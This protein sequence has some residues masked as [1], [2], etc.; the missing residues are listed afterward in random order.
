MA[1][2]R[3]AVL[4]ILLLLSVVS[5]QNPPQSDPQTVSFATQALTALKNVVAVGDHHCVHDCVLDCVLEFLSPHFVI[6]AV[7]EFAHREFQAQ[8]FTT[9]RNAFAFETFPRAMQKNLNDYRRE[10]ETPV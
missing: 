9:V 4:L 8:R 3:F 2:C 10:N 1:R 7:C 5:A 6:Q